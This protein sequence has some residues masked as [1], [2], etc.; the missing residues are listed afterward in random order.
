MIKLLPLKSL[1]LPAMFLL[2]IT[3][4][5]PAQDLYHMPA[6]TVTRWASPENPEAEKGMGGIK[7]F[8]RKGR[9]SVSLDAGDT[10]TLAAEPAGTT[11]TIRRIWITI[12][13]RDPEMLQGLT[14]Y[15]FWDGQTKP[16]VAAPVG[17][18]F[19]MGVGRMFPFETALFSS[20]EGRSFN[21]F[22][23]MPFRNGMKMILVNETERTQPSIFYDVDYT[24]GDPHN[25][26]ALYFHAYYKREDST[27]MR[28]DYEFLPHVTGKGRF[29]GVHF[30]V[31]ANQELFADSWWGEGEVMIYLDGD[32]EHPTLCGTGTEDYIGTGWGQGQYAHAYQGCHLADSE[33]MAYCFYRYHIPDP[34]YFYEDIRATIH[35]I[36]CCFGIHRE[37]LE[38][39]GTD[40]YE[41][42][43]KGEPT[44]YDDFEGWLFERYGDD[45]A[46]CV[47]F[48]LDKPVSGLP[49][50]D[51]FGKRIKGYRE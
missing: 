26:S 21:C 30:G 32:G 20:P 36:G 11:G 42:G 45:W 39:L 44:S 25:D 22:I 50:I 15:F 49:A 16:A 28:Q 3:N 35:Q 29:L 18:F 48:Y 4:L 33:N 12:R 47:Y 10:L 5:L 37:K 9:P 19:G 1:L 17:Y 41:T 24:I 7:N 46:S 6:N 8:G 38:A 51:P 14:L 34:V 40:L 23:S 13:E 2:L 27:H 31:V 43:N